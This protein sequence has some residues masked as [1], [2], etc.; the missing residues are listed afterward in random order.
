MSVTT[1]DR[2]SVLA[3]RKMKLQAGSTAR[4]EDLVA[5]VVL[6]HLGVSG[7]LAGALGSVILVRSMADALRRLRRGGHRAVPIAVHVRPTVEPRTVRAPDMTSND[8]AP[9]M[10]SAASSH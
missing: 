6:W 8:K 5:T 2:S 4:K 7:V 9:A 10:A 3:S 1:D